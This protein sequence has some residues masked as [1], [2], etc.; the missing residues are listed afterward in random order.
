M[1]RLKYIFA[2]FD[3]WVRKGKFIEKFSQW[4]DFPIGPGGFFTVSIEH[5]SGNIAQIVVPHVFTLRQHE[6]NFFFGLWEYTHQ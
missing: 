5:I 2:G 6:I 3:V 4:Q 1:S